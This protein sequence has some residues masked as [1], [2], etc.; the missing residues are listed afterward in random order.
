MKHLLLALLLLISCE[1]KPD[2]S[3]DVNKISG[4]ASVQE[5]N[6]IIFNLHN[7]NDYT[8]S[9]ME[10]HI[11][12]YDSGGGSVWDRDYN[13]NDINIGS[14]SSGVA[15]IAI[16]EA[17]RISNINWFIKSAETGWSKNGKGL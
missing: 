10:V 11:T 9:R 4:T 12:A 8:L 5:F 2:Y 13:V 14:K 16:T 7:G 15:M 6:I 17:D 3:L 1:T